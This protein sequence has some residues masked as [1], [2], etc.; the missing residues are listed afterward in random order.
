MII[1]MRVSEKKS[2][3]SS[4]R[5]ER[6]AVEKKPILI[7][8][9][10]SNLSDSIPESMLPNPIAAANAKESMPIPVFVNSNSAFIT[11][12][13][14]GSVVAKMCIKPCN[15]INGISA[16]TSC[17]FF[18]ISSILYSLNLFDIFYLHEK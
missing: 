17:M 7:S 10:P 2:R 1:K 9:I 15:T 5:A 12:D 11:G 4:R 6:I 14:A 8:L 3:E 13:S 16:G 18:P